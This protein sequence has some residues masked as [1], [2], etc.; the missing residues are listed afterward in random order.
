MA[1]HGQPSGRT[2]GRGKPGMIW[3]YI[4]KMNPEQLVQWAQG[5]ALYFTYL[6]SLSSDLEPE[7]RIFHAT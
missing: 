3:P 2:V 6:V 1:D 5:N 7:V 4:R